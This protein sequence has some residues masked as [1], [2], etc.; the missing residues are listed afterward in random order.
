MVLIEVKDEK[1]QA[2]VDKI[3]F[4]PRDYNPQLSGTENDRYESPFQVLTDEE[5]NYLIDSKFLHTKK[6][7]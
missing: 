7:N 2:I 1:L 4:D 5:L 6:P 3:G